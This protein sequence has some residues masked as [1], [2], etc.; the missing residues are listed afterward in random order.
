MRKLLPLVILILFVMPATA[1]EEKV[2]VVGLDGAEWDVIQPLMEEDKLPHLEKLM[3]EGKSGNLT[4]SLPVESPVAWTSMT[5]GTTP[6]KHGI[7]GFLER[8]DGEFVPTTAEDV[9]RS[10]AWDYAGREG[11]VVVMNVPQTF[12]PEKVNGSMISGYLSIRDEGY[13]YPADLQDELE[14][15]NYSIE[16]LEG[17]FE[18]GREEEFLRKLNSTV[19][20][21]TEVAKSLLDRTDWKLGFVTYTGLDRLQHYFWKYREGG[22]YQGV[23]DDHYVKLDR[24]IG[25]LMEHRD[26]NTT[27]IVVS[28]HGFGKLEKNVYLNTWLRKNGYLTLKGE[29]DSGTGSG[30]G[31]TQQD[32]VDLLSRFNLLEPVKRIFSAVGFNPGTKLPAPE[33]SDIDFSESEVYAGNYGGKIYLTSSVKNREEVL[34]RLEDKLKQIEDPE[35]GEKVVEDVYRPDDIYTGEQEDA[36]DLILDTK[37]AYRSVGFLGHSQVVK[38]PPVKSGTHRRDGIYIL[39]SGNGEEDADIT[40]V[41]PT[42]LE[43]LGIEIPSGMDGSSLLDG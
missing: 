43:A 2:I 20:K 10:R 40:D 27:V 17:G 19:E 36:P 28:D 3:R 18:K 15:T 37:G 34:D 41:A 30:L 33:L 12:P 25:E 1:Q 39:S 26:E 29:K 8:R 31:I 6:G 38:K 21:R 35:T 14:E 9:E 11:E 42:T 16:A 23:I 5:A 4:S 13:T 32:V 7:Y 24:Q 22:E